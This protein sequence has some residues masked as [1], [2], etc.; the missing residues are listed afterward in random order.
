MKTEHLLISISVKK[1]SSALFAAALLLGSSTAFA[2]VKIGT[3]PTT[4]EPNSNLEVEASTPGRKMKVDKTTGQVTITDGTQGA[5]KVFTSDAN[6][7]GSWQTAGAGCASFDA[8]GDNTTT[9]VVDTGVFTPVKL[10]ANNIVYSPSGAYDNTTGEYTIPADGFYIFHGSAGTYDVATGHTGARN[11]TIQLVSTAKGL[12]SYS[13]EPQLDYGVGAW[14]EVT[15]ANF[16]TAGDK[17][18]F[19]INSDHVSGVKPASVTT[20]SIFFSGTRID[21]NKN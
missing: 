2:Q 20:A 1:V 9:P 4:I 8:K 7:G 6:G 21:C 5:G 19:R 17:V 18:S 11:T 10:I 15:S 14:Q 12:L 3:N 16:F 13:V